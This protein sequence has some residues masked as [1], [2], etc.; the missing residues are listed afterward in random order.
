LQHHGGHDVL[1]YDV[2]RERGEELLAAG[3]D[4][5][6]RGLG[7]LIDR[8]P[9]KLASSVSE[10]VAHADVV[11]V[12]VQTP[13]APAYGGETPMPDDRRDFEY[14]FLVQAVRDVCRAAADQAKPIALVVVSTAL[15]G[16]CNAH[17]RGLLNEYVTLVY[18]P[19][20]IAMGT[21]I[22]DFLRPEFVLLG[23]DRREALDPVVDVY[24]QLHDRPVFKTSI[25]SAELIKV[26]YNTVISA[27][28]VI[29]N[30][31]MEI[32][33]KTG[34]D[35]DEVVDALSLATDRVVSPA[36][37]RGGMGDGGACHPRDLIAMSW[38]AE[39]LDISYDLLGQMA[40][41][42]EAQSG[43]LADLAERWAEQTGLEVCILGK[44]YKPESALTAGSPALLL[45]HQL[46]QR[47][48]TPIHKDIFVDGEFDL[49]SEP[50]VYVIG[51]KHTIHASCRFEAGSVVLD[52][53]GYMPDQP[54]VTV[55]R[56]GRKS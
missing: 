46:E 20:F 5:G 38:L 6:E 52:P 56:I 55:V 26:A 7:D 44:A 53:H 1:G 54:G 42:R 40:Y 39:R 41:A 34:A 22:S 49:P 28:I 30:T 19:L 13:H 50:R 21:T 2:H 27:K 47:G 45:A 10:V 24:A 9:L 12:A 3:G 36:Y 35:C 14:G 29:G 48:H 43:W 15:P 8:G 25:E 37:L 31:L 32:C 4:N 51:T 33:E 11:F 17:L 18:G 16:T 23:A